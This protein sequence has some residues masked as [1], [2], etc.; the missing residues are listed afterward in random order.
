MNIKDIEKT[1]QNAMRQNKS[2]AE[3]SRD[4]YNMLDSELKIAKCANNGNLSVAIARK[5]FLLR[6]ENA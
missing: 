2:A 3:M 5:Q 1:I 6:T 4:I